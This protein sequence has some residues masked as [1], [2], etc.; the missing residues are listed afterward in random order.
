MINNSYS[1][2]VLSI[3][4]GYDRCGLAILEKK[5]GTKDILLAS[6]CEQTQ[7][8][9]K[10]SERLF[11]VVSRIETLI[12]E[13][14]PNYIAIETLFFSNNKTTAMHVAE[15]RGAIIFLAKKHGIKIK[16]LN[17]SEIKLA[18]TGDGRSTKQQMIKMIQLIT[19]YRADAKDDEYDAVAVGIAFL[20]LYREGITQLD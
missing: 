8:N 7:S 18:V 13:Y 12:F 14:S 3:D 17:P 1:I 5:V 2:R 10:F 4:P 9:Q 15:V 16:E 19:G 6:Y 20:A 11:Q